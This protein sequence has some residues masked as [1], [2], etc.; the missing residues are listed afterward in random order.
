MKITLILLNLFLFVTE[1][2]YATEIQCPELT[3]EQTFKFLAKH[4]VDDKGLESWHL[5]GVGTLYEGVL[6]DDN[7]V[8]MTE[9][10]EEIQLPYFGRNTL[11]V[12]Y[13]NLKFKDGTGGQLAI[14]EMILGGN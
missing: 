7:P 2:V 11:F 9:K 10:I 1:K 12:C 4:K 3:T 5:Y 14:S 8:T 13:Y 6:R